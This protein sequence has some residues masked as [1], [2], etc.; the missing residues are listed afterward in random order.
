[1][2]LIMAGMDH[3]MAGI[4]FREKFSFTKQTQAEIL[5]VLRGM[6]GIRGAVLISTCNRTELYLSIAP[7]MDCDPFQ[8]L[9]RAAALEL[10]PVR[11]HYTIRRGP[12]VFRHL[13]RLACG[14]ESQIL[15]E[16]QILT[17]VK[18]ALVQA[19]DSGATDSDLEV[20]FRMAITA[21][22]KIKTVVKFSKAENS[23]ALKTLAILNH[24]LL[25]PERRHVLVIGNGEVGRLVAKTLV[26]RGFLVSMTLRQYKYRSNEVPEGVRALDYA[27]RYQALRAFDAVVSATSSPHYTLTYEALKALEALPSLM[28]DLAVP[29]DIELEIGCRLPVKLF[30][31]DTIA[32]GAVA[33]SNQN[34]FRQSEA[35]IRKYY[36]DLLKWYHYKTFGNTSATEGRR[37]VS[38]QV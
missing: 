10:I 26:E 19:R 31:I 3:S 6:E 16:D 9:C 11:H 23:V 29:R 15:G 7:H 12:E 14:L 13:S 17:Q 27:E 32:R 5:T 22:K 2:N 38:A 33:E 30:D 4:D 35:I 37:A 24:E 8:K 1:M 20:A 18:D 25:S 28:I 36:G 21:A 34:Q